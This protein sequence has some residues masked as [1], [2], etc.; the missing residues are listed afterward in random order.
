MNETIK[1]IESSIKEI[2]FNNTANVYSISETSK[3]G[4]KVGWVDE[5]NLSEKIINEIN[6]LNENQYS[7]VITI[8]NNYLILKIEKIK[9]NIIEINEKDELNKMIIFETNKQLNKFSRIFFNKS[10][11]NH[12]INEK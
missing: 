4:G 6:K 12:S 9:L 8:G 10:K 1:K 2:G 7:N 5:K 11:L 3:L